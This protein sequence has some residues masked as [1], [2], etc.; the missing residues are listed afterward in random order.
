MHLGRRLDLIARRDYER[1]SR[2]GPKKG[3]RRSR[4][5]EEDEDEDEAAYSSS[6]ANTQQQQVKVEQSSLAPSA[7]RPDKKKT[8]TSTPKKPRVAAAPLDA[9]ANA[10]AATVATPSLADASLSASQPRRLDGCLS[11]IRSAAFQRNFIFH[12]P[13]GAV[14]E[15]R[16]LADMAAAQEPLP[17]A[18]FL[19]LARALAP[20]SEWSARVWDFSDHEAIR[21]HFAA[22]RSF[23]LLPSADVSIKDERLLLAAVL[24]AAVDDP[25]KRSYFWCAQHQG[26]AAAAV[27]VV[28]DNDEVEQEQEHVVEDE[29]SSGTLE[30]QR[31]HTC[32]AALCAAPVASA[33]I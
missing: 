3:V 16:H 31:E 18:A 11:V 25:D 1:D 33:E 2:P 5:G 13:S 28:D 6:V 30:R 21:G 26:A 9:L 32:T 15:P 14:L 24:F 12:A 27:V 29:S 17:Q 19:G 4:G 22:R 10:A 20:S 23:V 8:K 7:P